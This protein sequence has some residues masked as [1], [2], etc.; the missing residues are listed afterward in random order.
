MEYSLDQEEKEKKEI[1]LTNGLGW[2]T[3][4]FCAERLLSDH[5]DSVNDHYHVT[6]K[7]R[8]AAH[9]ESCNL[10]RI[11]Y[12]LYSKRGYDRHHLKQATSETEKGIKCV[13]NNMENILHF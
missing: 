2:E 3:C 12:Q 13:A 6:G 9:S 1:G 8:G 4:L 7:L 10:R 11:Q 5:K